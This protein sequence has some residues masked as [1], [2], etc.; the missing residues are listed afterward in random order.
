M[1]DYGLQREMPKDLEAEQSVIGSLIIDD[2]Y[3]SEVK[4]LLSPED[5]YYNDM[6]LIYEAILSLASDGKGVDIV[7][8]KSCL[9]DKGNLEKVGGVGVISKLALKVP[10]AVKVMDYASV[11]KEK[12]RLRDIIRM[13]EKTI[14]SAYSNE[15]KAADILIEAENNIFN[16]A[17]S[18][19]STDFHHV[20]DLI[21]PMINKIELLSEQGSRITGLETGFTDLDA[22]TSG[23]Q[24][25][26]LI[27]LAARPSMGKTA[28]ALNMLQHIAT[29]GKKVCAMFSLEMSK[30]QLLG[31]MV[32]SESLVDAQKLR[33]GNLSDDDWGKLAM[34]S[35]VLADAEIYIDDT[36]GINLSELR[37][38]CRKLKMKKGLD[39]IVIDYLQLMS[40]SGK[41]KSREQEISEISRGL[42]AVAREMNVPVIAL[43]QLSR[44]PELRADKRPILSDLRESGAI[45]QDADVVMFLYRD[46]YY[47]EDTELQNIAELIIAKQRNGPTG[48]VKL[49]WN[50]QYTKFRNS[51]HS[52]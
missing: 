4:A 51:T 34:G 13:N 6:R 26:D 35:M 3:I 38:K 46:A 48:T 23:L 32:C 49:I 42:K 7:L 12:S 29:K 15:I 16:A 52:G 37:S 28:V 22:K 20:K 25:S 33:N 36:A 2:M 5:F 41:T 31:R 17:M 1:D 44:A 18:S 30:E 39:L 9:S 8:L 50:A 24:N 43:S 19:T 14:A 11:V 40:G 10:S 21:T 45:E 47:N 27:L